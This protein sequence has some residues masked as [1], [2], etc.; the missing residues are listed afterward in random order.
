MWIIAQYQTVKPWICL[1][2]VLHG[3]AGNQRHPFQTLPLWSSCGKLPLGSAR[4]RA[5]SQRFIYILRVFSMLVCNVCFWNELSQNL[6]CLF[7]LVSPVIRIF[8]IIRNFGLSTR[9]LKFRVPRRPGNWISTVMKKIFKFGNWSLH[10]NLL[11]VHFWGSSRLQQ[12]CGYSSSGTWWYL[13]LSFS[14]CLLLKVFK[15]SLRDCEV[16]LVLAFYF[17]ARRKRDRFYI[18]NQILKFLLFMISH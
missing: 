14:V 16:L 8:S 18:I 15:G 6:F 11:T 7:M 10:Y 3:F 5:F 2:N 9:F 17:S 1:T 4:H 12:F 13:S